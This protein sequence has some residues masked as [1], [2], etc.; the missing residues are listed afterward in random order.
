MS[1]FK[2]IIFASNANTDDL[3]VVDDSVTSYVVLVK[4]LLYPVLERFF[5]MKMIFRVFSS[6]DVYCA[7]KD[8]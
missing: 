1:T 2:I 7:S 3:V 8:M 4:M 6:D 5:V